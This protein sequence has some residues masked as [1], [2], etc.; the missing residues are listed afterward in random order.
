MV[1]NKENF[2]QKKKVKRLDAIII[3]TEFL[4]V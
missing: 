3:V 2:G 4:F 1:E